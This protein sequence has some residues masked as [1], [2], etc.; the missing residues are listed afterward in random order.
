MKPS[1][2]L[3][4]STLLAA[5]LVSSGVVAQDSTY[6]SRPIQLLVSFPAGSIV[7]VMARRWDHERGP[8]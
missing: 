4:G 5:A 8:A 2:L 3:I 7:D 6:P 1:R